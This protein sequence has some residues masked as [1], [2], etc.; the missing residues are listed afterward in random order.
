L[1]PTKKDT[2][3]TL[4]EGNRRKLMKEDV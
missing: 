1:E 4:E 3:K 2:Q